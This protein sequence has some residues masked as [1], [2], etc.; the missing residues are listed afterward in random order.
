MNITTKSTLSNFLNEAEKTGTPALKQFNNYCK[1]SQGKHFE[2]INQ[3]SFDGSKLLA[4]TA[5]N[6]S[7]L[8]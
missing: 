1:L 6:E 3:F 5:D 4:M 8:V 2:T 7:S